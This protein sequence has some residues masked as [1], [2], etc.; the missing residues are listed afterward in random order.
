MRKE[1]RKRGRFLTESFIHHG[2]LLLFLTLFIQQR[3]EGVSDNERQKLVLIQSG[4]D[5]PSKKNDPDVPPTSGYWPTVAIG[6]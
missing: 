2:L 5:E 3:A 1:S 6:T 4:G